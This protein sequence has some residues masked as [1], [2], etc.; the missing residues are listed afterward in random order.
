MRLHI[1]QL[2]MILCCMLAALVAKAQ[3]SSY[4]LSGRITNE[5]GEPLSDVTVARP[6]GK[7][8]IATLTNAKGIFFLPGVISSHT[9]LVTHVG[10]Q[11]QVIAVKGR[12]EINIVLKSSNTYLDQVVVQA[13]GVTNQR[14]TTGNIS[15]VTA[16][17]IDKQPVINP[18][19]ILQGR[20]PGTSIT[21]V[22]GA[23]SGSIKI[24]IRG[25]SSIDPTKPAEPLYVIDGV[26]MTT[27]NLSNVESIAA[28]SAVSQGM[29]Q[30][31]M[32][33]PAGGQSPFFNINPA[34]IESIEV[35]KDADATA[36]YG[37]RGANGVILVTTK[38]GKAG[39]AGTE[40]NV[41]TGFSKVTRF[42]PLLNTQQYVALRKAALAND[43]L[44]IDMMSAPDLV[45]WD[46]TRYTDWQ[47]YA[48]G[49]TGRTVSAQLSMQGGT[50]LTNFRAS[51]GYNYQR[52]ITA[53][54]G[55]NQRGSMAMAVQHKTPNQ[56]F[57]LDLSAQY[58]ITHSNL[59]YSAGSALL[60]PHAPAI[61]NDKGSLNYAGWAP[62]ATSYA[63]AS[64][65]QPYE[66]TAHLLNSNLVLSYAIIRGL[67]ARINLGYN[68]SQTAQEHTLPIRS[69][70]PDMN[71]RGSVSKGRSYFHNV[72]SEPQLEYTTFLSRG[73]ITALA[74][75]SYQQNLTTGLLTA[76]SNYTNDLLLGSINAAPTKQ[77]VEN[78]AQYKYAGAFLRL[79][80]NW[81]N[82]YILNI[83]G[84]R[85]G[86]SRFA[87]G[88]QFGNFGSIGAA[89]IFSESKALKASSVLSFGKLRASYGVTGSDQIGD[90]G[91]LSL[92]EFGSTGQYGGQQPLFPTRFADSLL[93]WEENR[94][95][96]LALQLG[97][98]KDRLT[99]QVAWYRNRCD[100]QLLSMPIA[101]Q[102]GFTSVISNTPANVQ[103]TGL[104]VNLDILAIKGTTWQ[105]QTRL[106][107]AANRNKLLSYPNFDQSPYKSRFVVGR[108]LNLQRLLHFTGVNPATGEY[109]FAD[110]TGDQAITVDFTGNTPDDRTIIDMT[111]QYEAGLTT[112]LTFQQWS[113]SALWFH[114]KQKGFNA[115]VG[116]EQPG[117][118]KNQPSQVMQYW[119]KPGDI[120]AVGKPLNYGTNNS[121]QYA[122]YSDA[123]ISD[124]SFIRLQNVSLSYSCPDAWLK[125][126]HLSQFRLFIQGEN[127]LL[128]TNYKGSDPEIQQFGSL[129]RPAILT[130]GISC[131]L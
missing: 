52:D 42:F 96:E 59:I 3:D 24:E 21:N 28:G 75:A 61:F 49:G 54:A 71:P 39:K 93:R 19:Q 91:F 125:K 86:S 7:Q 99:L 29:I 16:T 89:W 45:A 126:W 92:W 105:L 51:A 64:L 67:T 98:F 38:K 27:L 55:G 60:P 78:S 107:V 69:L 6:N 109:R 17:E 33:S 34:D 119:Q 18:L 100:N 65:L 35:L 81:E 10:Y 37:S 108:P 82:R 97:F 46:T 14:I 15:K 72:I 66:S 56:K 106:F 112:E 2:S 25:R 77:I 111:P 124:A 120:A 90:Y 127:L 68:N 131:K 87:S 62:L 121:N 115:L 57:T 5:R 12:T 63:F 95:L 113:L 48:F 118:R 32:A 31:G 130:A 36:I 22:S 84:R 47:R 104:E 129:P 53:I 102:S 73:K 110:L 40:L 20:T 44:A 116:A 123:R 88:R 1:T 9:I 23:A 76:G 114:R 41:Y 103:N 79:S 122:F 8:G 128:V 74:G 94:K 30:S 80:Y 117:A 83:S 43:G 85:D 4:T 50:A 70:N 26:P 11:R 58:S 13:Y 101:S